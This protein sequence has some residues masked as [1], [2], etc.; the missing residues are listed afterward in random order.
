MDKIINLIVYADKKDF[1]KH[2]YLKAK[3]PCVA[4]LSES[5]EMKSMEDIEKFID[6]I[7][8]AVSTTIHNFIEKDKSLA[9]EFR[10]YLD[11]RGMKPSL[12]LF[13]KTTK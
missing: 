4:T 9:E 8:T 13:F 5:D 10:K 3:F 6:D 2:D 7:E 12:G 1:E 11:D